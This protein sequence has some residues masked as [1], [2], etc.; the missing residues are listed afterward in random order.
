MEPP[1][2]ATDIAVRSYRY[3]GVEMRRLRVLVVDDDPGLC[4]LVRVTLDV[5]GIEVIAAHHVVEAERHVTDPVPDA[6]VLDIG[7]PGIYGLFYCARLRENP[8]TARVPIVIVSGSE[9]TE[10]GAISAGATAFVRKPFDPL[11]LLTVLERAIGI[12]PLGRAFDAE[13]SEAV[14]G[15]H[16]QTVGKLVE[17]GMRRHDDLEQAYRRTI[18]AIAGSLEYRGLETGDHAQR[19][20]AYAMRL[21]VEVAPALTDDPGLEWGFLLHD[22]GNLG[23]PD[24]VL[25]KRGA[26]TSADWQVLRQHTVIGAELL[27]SAPLVGERGLEVV[28]SHHERWDGTGYPDGLEGTAIPLSARIFAVADALDAM[29]SRRAHRRPLRWDAAVARIRAGAG[30]QFDP[31]VVDGF[32]VCEPDLIAIRDRRLD[33]EPGE[34]GASR[35]VAAAAGGYAS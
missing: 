11:E 29:T 5:E 22:V 18:V 27:A 20:A 17:L 1:A 24:R 30:T 28:R 34:P 32:V 23:L 16:A 3:Q 25:L 19:V 31:D 10:E 6:I 35:L 12:A 13:L 2:A 7:L 9:S 8:R 14:T 4:E 21:A 15:R 26:L 33:D